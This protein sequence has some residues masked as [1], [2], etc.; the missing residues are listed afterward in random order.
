MLVGHLPHL[1]RLASWLLIGDPGKEILRFRN[2]GIVCLARAGGRWLLQ[3][4][5]APELVGDPAA[6]P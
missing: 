3:W 6:H 5:L 1:S 4:I 2:G